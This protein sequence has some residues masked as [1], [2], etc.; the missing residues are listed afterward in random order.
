MTPHDDQTREVRRDDGEL[1]GVVRLTAT[2]LWTPCAVFGLPLAE[3]RAEEAAT[4]YILDHGLGYLA[5][6][7]EVREGDTWVTAQII[8]AR[9]REVTV[10]FTDYGHPRLFN[11]RRTL[12]D[13]L[14]EQL[15]LA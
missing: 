4:Q 15:R 10:S 9:P 2:G 8:E 7:W 5:E 1:I 3:A 12:Q 13:P 6:R 11:S 14:P